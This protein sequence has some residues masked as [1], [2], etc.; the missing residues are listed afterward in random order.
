MENSGDKVTP[1][2]KTPA[3]VLLFSGKRKSGKDYITDRLFDRLGTN[4]TT[5]IK[6]SAPIKTHWAETHDLD[7]EELMSA[8]KYKEEHRQDMIKWS[9]QIRQKDYG[10]FCQAAVEMFNAYEK[11]IW[12]VSDTRRRSDLKWFKENYD[13]AV[14]TVRVL[15]DDDVRRQRGWVFTAGVDDAET[16]CDLDGVTDWDWTIMNN[17]NERELQAGM[18]SILSWVGDIL[19]S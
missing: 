17:G 2:N 19:N 15:A 8:G 10:Y 12:I 9:E 3:C 5:M 16:E 14:K 6:I 11:P 4:N 7:F 1:V 13:I 18:Q